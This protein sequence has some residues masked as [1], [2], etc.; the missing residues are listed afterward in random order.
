VALYHV[1]CL[2]YAVSGS[3]KVGITDLKSWKAVMVNMLYLLYYA[4][5]SK[6]FLFV[7]I[8]SGFFFVNGVKICRCAKIH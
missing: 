6:R 4:Y 2:L 3:A 8:Y 5:V 1:H 7:F